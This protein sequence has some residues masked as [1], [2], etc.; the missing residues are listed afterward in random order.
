[1]DCGEAGFSVRRRECLSLPTVCPGTGFDMKTCSS[2]IS[3]QGISLH[4]I[5][6]SVHC[7]FPPKNI[8]YMLIVQHPVFVV[9][10]EFD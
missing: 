1:M 6:M 10:C 5:C 8:T 9:Y 7:I 3:C 2:G 4:N